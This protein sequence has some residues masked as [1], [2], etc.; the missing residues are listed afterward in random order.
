MSLFSFG[1]GIYFYSEGC[2]FRVIFLTIRIGEFVC[3][4]QVEM[5]NF[6]AKDNVPFHSV[7]FPACL[8]GADDDFTIVNHMSATGRWAR[9]EMYI[10]MCVCVR[11]SFSIPEEVLGAEKHYSILEITINSC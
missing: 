6:M 5:Y 1:G 11:P 3:L 8:L 4:I 9:E 7:I 2:P 10:Y